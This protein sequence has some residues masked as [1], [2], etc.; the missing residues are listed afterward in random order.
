MWLVALCGGGDMADGTLLLGVLLQEGQTPLHSAAYGGH[1]EAIELLVSKNADVQSKD[2]VSPS[3]PSVPW[4]A[5]I[6]VC[7]V[8]V[9]HETARCARGAEGCYCMP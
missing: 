3:P 7:G 9:V 4:C 5:S 2:N 1:Q 6:S 8:W